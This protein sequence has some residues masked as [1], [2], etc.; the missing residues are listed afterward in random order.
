M[1]LN[2]SVSLPPAPLPTPALLPLQREGS[3]HGETQRGGTQHGGTQRGGTQRG[4]A[5]AA[6]VAPLRG[7]VPPPPPGG[8]LPPFPASA[9]TNQDDPIPPLKHVP[10]SAG[11]GNSQDLTDLPKDQDLQEKDL[12]KDQDV[13]DLLRKNRKDLRSEPKNRTDQNQTG[14]VEESEDMLRRHKQLPSA[15][16]ASPSANKRCAGV[17]ASHTRISAINAPK[18]T[19]SAAP[20]HMTVYPST[21]SQ[22]PPMISGL[23]D[24]FWGLGLRV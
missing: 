11:V 8:V 12:P 3:Q 5:G 21:L 22:E 1:P 15:P 18:A 7:A 4:E 2:S 19:Q 20:L 14:P 23:G 16:A 10:A 17:L 9:N 6:S 13:T 24:G